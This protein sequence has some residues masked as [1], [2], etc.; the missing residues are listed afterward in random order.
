MINLL[1]KELNLSINK[2]FYVL[3]FMLGLLFFIPQWFFTLVL[4][5]LFWITVPQIYAGYL[6]NQDNNFVAALPVTKKDIVQSKVLA[7]VIIEL[8]HLL[9]AII[10]AIIHNELYG[11]WNFGLDANMS[12]IG[13]GFIIYGIFNIAFIPYFFKTGTR[14]GRPTIV[15]TVT[16]LL[17]AAVVEYGVIR[18]EF[19]REIFEGSLQSNLIVLAIGIV[20]FVGLT[21]IS[22]KISEKRFGSIDL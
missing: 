4:M 15:G 1:Y 17:F 18:F 10:F 14:F 13:V 2:F 7:L 21:F 20:L 8:L 6:S 12:Y 11:I 3:P 19:M 22:V 5:Y 16:T 9:V